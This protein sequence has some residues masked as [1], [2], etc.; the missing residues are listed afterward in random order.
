MVSENRTGD[1]LT[2]GFSME[3]K[4]L[5]QELPVMVATYYPGYQGTDG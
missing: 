2:E 1:S 4:R 3:E 5:D